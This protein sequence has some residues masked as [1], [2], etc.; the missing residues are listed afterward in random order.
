[1]LKFARLYKDFPKMPSLI[2]LKVLLLV[3][4]LTAVLTSTAYAD[5]QATHPQQT[6][7]AVHVPVNSHDP[8][9]PTLLQ[10]NAPTPEE[11]SLANQELLSK[12]AELSRQVSSLTT[13]TEVL[14]RELSGQLFMYGAAVT[15][16]SFFVGLMV[17]RLIFRRD[18]W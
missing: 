1:M 6:A 3:W 16:V 13:Q 5:T 11:L 15:A 17:G 10:M 7:Q 4:V 2:K 12:N 14:V 9:A 18:R 8:N